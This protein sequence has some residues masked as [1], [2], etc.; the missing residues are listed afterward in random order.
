[1]YYN[2]QDYNSAKIAINKAITL[3]KKINENLTRR[4]LFNL[5][6][7]VDTLNKIK[8]DEIEVISYLNEAY[9]LKD[10]LKIK[11]IDPSPKMQRAISILSTFEH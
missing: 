10:K 2:N 4:Y 1:M 8:S 5:I 11:Q 3:Q 6:Y 7:M 9:S